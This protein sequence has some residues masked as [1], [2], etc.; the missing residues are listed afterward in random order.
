M[1]ENKGYTAYVVGGYVRD[2]LLGIESYD[3]DIATS[4]PVKVVQDLFKDS[5]SNDYG[6]VS[7][8]E[9]KYS[10]EI[11]TYRVESLYENRHPGSLNYTDDI[12]KD[13]DRRDFTVN[14]IL[15]D[16]DGNILDPLGGLKD[17]KSKTVRVIGDI[18]SKFTE[19]PLRILRALRLQITRSM[20]IEKDADEFIRENIDLL[21]TLSYERRKRELDKIFSSKNLKEG[22]VVLK[23]Y[24]VLK[25]LGIKPTREFIQTGDVLSSWAQF[26]FDKD[27]PFKKSDRLAITNIKSII[28]LGTIDSHSLLKYGLDVNIKAGKI[29]GFTEEQVLKLYED[30]PIKSESDLAIT[31][32]EISVW[33]GATKEKI[34]I[35]K[36]DLLNVIISGNLPNKD[37][38][39]KEYII[40]K[41][42]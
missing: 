42:K 8:T 33:T 11:T 16:S 6:C 20:Q 26:D 13:L 23:H 3:V 32:D 27:Y 35:I 41:W 19:D 25:C 12:L 24:G 9:G 30:M 28:A 18:E 40:R 7:F 5:A 21:S 4:A 10:V 38:E 22:I 37:I 36:K 34:G 14:A 29:L 15:M 1:I 17:L 31:G 39:I 2:K